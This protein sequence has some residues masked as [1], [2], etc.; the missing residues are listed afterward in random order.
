MENMRDY[1]WL[2][3][4]AVAV[5]VAIIWWLSTRKPDE[6][7]APPAARRV[8]A[9][10]PPPVFDAPVASV[11]AAPVPVVPE[12][13]T[14]PPAPAAA[15]PPGPPDNLALLKG[16]GPKL[17]A[18]LGTLGVRRFDQIAA[19]TGDDVARIDA[20]LGTFQGRIAKDAWVEQAA[21]LAVGDVAGF[22]AKFG[23]LDGAL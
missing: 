19:W 17:V 1:W 12:P 10:P 15:A 7:E 14:A 5:V 3:A 11:A 9:A 6:D 4:L 13:E 23:K 18:L 2:I 20:Q 16:V 21:F 22:E 8:E